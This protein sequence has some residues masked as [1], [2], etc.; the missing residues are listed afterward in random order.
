M[1]LFVDSMNIFYPYTHIFCFL[2][3]CFP[4]QHFVEHRFD[5]SQ[6]QRVAQSACDSMGEITS[7]CSTLNIFEVS[8]TMATISK[9]Y[10]NHP[11]LNI[12]SNIK[13]IFISTICYDVILEVLSNYQ[14]I[15]VASSK[16]IR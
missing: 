7:Y 6:M 15:F 4:Y 11:L 2:G 5:Q 9:I 16:T 1:I 10:T 12:L 8:K 14:Y 3:G 13:L